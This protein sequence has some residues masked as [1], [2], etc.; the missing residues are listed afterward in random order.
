MLSAEVLK[1]FWSYTVAQPSGCI[2]WVGGLVDGYGWFNHCK[3]RPEGEQQAHRL[4]WS[5]ANNCAVPESM[6]ILHSC[7]R[8]CCVNPSHLRPGSHKENM[9]EMRERK[10]SPNNAGMKNPRCK[11]TDDQVAEIRVRKKTQGEP[12]ALIAK[13]YDVTPE[14]TSMICR[15]KYRNALSIN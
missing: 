11:L 6:L 2:D 5:I 1:R 14:M 10:R 13:D 3:E 12:Y 9:L 7:D 8:R 15:G 4:S